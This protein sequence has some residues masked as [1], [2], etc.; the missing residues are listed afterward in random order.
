MHWPAGD[1][2]GQRVAISPFTTTDTPISR[3]GQ[4][5]VD[6]LSLRPLS[7][8]QP[9]GISARSAE[10]EKYPLNLIWVMPA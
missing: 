8:R 9:P 5:G 10:S 7:A 6:R 2:D 3:P 1:G 4:G